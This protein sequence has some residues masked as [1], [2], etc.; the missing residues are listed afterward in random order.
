[1]RGSSRIV[2]DRS[3]TALALMSIA[4]MSAALVVLL[5][6]IFFR[7]SGAFVFKGTVEYRRMMLEKF[8]RGEGAAI[9]KEIEEAREARRPVYE[10]VA[11]FEAELDTADV[12]Y[13]RLYRREFSE[14][15]GLLS[16]LLGPLPGD[17]MP[18]L[19]R[20]QYGETRWDRARATLQEI[21]FVEEYDHSD[22]SKMGKKIASPRVE[23]FRGTSLEPLFGILE[24]DLQAM[25]RPRMV[26]YWRFLFN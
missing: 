6:P 2:F 7:G 24:R 23:R 8:G 20:S 15:R 1:M 12:E 3:F 11:R 5:F 16:E 26:F 13:R 18:V 17:P 25:M 14:L 4:L 21:L 9:A 10:I 22:Q 19:A